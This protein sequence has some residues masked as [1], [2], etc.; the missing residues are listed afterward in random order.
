MV[1]L[2][3]RNRWLVSRDTKPA[4]LM[5]GAR[6][7]ISLGRR[8]WPTISRGI[9]LHVLEEPSATVDADMSVFYR[10]AREY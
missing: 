5:R 1:R 8:H 10:L 2:E 7:Q 9:P 4:K 6:V 3:A